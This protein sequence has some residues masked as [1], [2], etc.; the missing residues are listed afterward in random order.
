M[1]RKHLRKEVRNPE[2]E[3]TSESLDSSPSSPPLPPGPTARWIWECHVCRKSFIARVM[4]AV[5]GSGRERL[6]VWDYERG[7]KIPWQEVQD[8]TEPPCPECGNPAESVG[9][10]VLDDELEKAY[11]QLQLILR[12]REG[13]KKSREEFMARTEGY[14][15]EHKEQGKAARLFGHGLDCTCDECKDDRLERDRDVPAGA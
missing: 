11:V 4:P 6:Y 8:E 3:P 10:A 12:A 9:P 5:D 14:S 2:G 7:Q 1:R 13:D 15:R